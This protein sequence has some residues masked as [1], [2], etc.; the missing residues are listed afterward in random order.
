M[1][2][3]NAMTQE[4]ADV[5]TWIDDA[6]HTAITDSMRYS[7]RSEWANANK[8]GV[9]D[10]GG[11][12]EYVRRTIIDEEFTDPQENFAAAFVGTAVGDYAEKA[13]QA[14]ADAN[15]P[16]WHVQ[17]QLSVTVRLVIYG[18]ELRLPGHPDGLL[19]TPEKHVVLDFKSKDK[20]GTTRRQGP[21][22]K[23]RFQVTLYTKALIDSGEIDE[24]K[25]WCVL[26]FIDRSGSE[27][28]PVSFAWK[29][30]PAILQQAEQWMEDVIYA[31]QH[32]E[33][34]SRDMPRSWCWEV[35]PRATACRGFDTDVEGV[36]DAPHIV[37]AAAQYKEANAAMRQLE[38][39]KES[40]KS[41]LRGVAGVAGDWVVRWID[42]PPTTV[43]EQERAGYKRLDIR[44]VPKQAARKRVRKTETNEGEASE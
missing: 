2:A 26:T 11:C 42:V 34:T 25:A 44:A 36:I 41:V 8:I 39:D 31:V 15:H 37:E 21:E 1:R 13:L 17:T 10:I 6:V 38:K 5:A 16:E 7:T 23:Q 14:F 24:D 28:R 20:L 4:E 33:E 32:G 12:R 29:Y 35:C 9:S 40:A 27:P 43:A 18:F 22:D 3:V 19:K 30:D